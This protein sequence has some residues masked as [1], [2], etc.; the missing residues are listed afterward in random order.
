MTA[1]QA[2]GRP[3]TFGS[4]GNPD[5]H[6][7]AEGPRCDPHSPWARAGNPHP[8]SRRYCLAI[9]YCGQ[10]PHRRAAPSTPAADTIVDIR[11]VAKGSRRGDW[12][13]ARAQL[14]GR[15]A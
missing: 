4:C 12:R 14:Q 2:A 5:T 3:C 15:P 13:Q 7:Y 1:D 11:L 10:C 8:S 9:C 6:P